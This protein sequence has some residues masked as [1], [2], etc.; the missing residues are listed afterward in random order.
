MM[1]KT[2]VPALAAA[3]LALPSIAQGN[4][5]TLEQAIEIAKA[6]GLVRLLEADRDEGRW[7]LEGC[8]ADDGE[9]EVD[10]RRSTGDVIKVEI[11]SDRDDDCL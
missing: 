6:E 11:D 8:T 3:C 2:I 5:V 10:I 1:M 9:I 7:E 4:G